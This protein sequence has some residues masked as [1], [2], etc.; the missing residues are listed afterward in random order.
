MHMRDATITDTNVTLHASIKPHTH[1]YQIV[2]REYL[3][4]PT[5]QFSLSRTQWRKIFRRGRLTLTMPSKIQLRLTP[6]QVGVAFVQINVT[7]TVVSRGL[8]FLIPPL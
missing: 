1:G 6:L 5:T 7:I 3:K 8:N 2:G 4:T